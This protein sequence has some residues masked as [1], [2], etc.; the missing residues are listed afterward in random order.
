MSVGL[1]IFAHGTL[2]GNMLAQAEANLGPMPLDTAVIDV[3]PG[4][5]PAQL[6]E[7]AGQALELIDNGDGVIALIDMFGATPSNIAHQLEHVDI[8]LHGLNL[9]MLVRAHNY[10]NLPLQEL[11]DRISEGGQQAIFS[12]NQPP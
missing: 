2:G 10:A 7:T 8:Y 5:D 12:G 6:L 3:E 11:A 1:L 4:D 9:A